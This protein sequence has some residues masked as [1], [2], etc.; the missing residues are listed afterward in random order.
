MDAVFNNFIAKGD[1]RWAPEG[2][3]SIRGILLDDSG[4]I[5]RAD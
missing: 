3:A 1:I 5:V 4:N 2:I